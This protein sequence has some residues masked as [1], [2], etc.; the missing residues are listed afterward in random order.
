MADAIPSPVL[1]SNA[2]IRRHPRVRHVARRMSSP[3]RSVGVPVL[4]GPCRGLRV[5]VGDSTLLRVLSRIEPEF[6]DAW[7]QH[8]STG[9]VVWDVGANIGWFSLLAARVA[10]P[11]AR[12]TAFEPVPT[13]VA[14]IKAN[15]AR[16]GLPI[17]VVP[18]AVAGTSGWSSFD[19]ESSLTGRLS[20]DGPM[21]VPTITLDDWAARVGPPNVI[22]LD[23]EG[24]EVAVLADGAK[25][26][27]SVHRPAILCEC[28]GTQHEIDRVLQ[29]SS[30][31]VSVIEMPWVPV[32]NAP[33]WVH[34]L[35]L[36]N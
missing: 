35:G 32:R 10:G 16:N 34:L 30:Y 9:D 28:H 23:I 18:A 33:W 7:T 36:P 22:K 13:N 5:S 31:R 4:R 21:I 2:F 25:Q 15:A 29:Q 14:Q 8:V 1:A 26:L 19:A 27:L 12:V 24:D 6:E 20:T 3:L 11:S 17:V